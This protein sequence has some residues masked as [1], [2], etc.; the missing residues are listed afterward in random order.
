MH[1]PEDGEGRGQEGGKIG[2]RGIRKEEEEEK[3]KKEVAE[4][5]EKVV[6]K[7]YLWKD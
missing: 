6:K 2:T 3:L 7:R 4:N 1:G 5:A